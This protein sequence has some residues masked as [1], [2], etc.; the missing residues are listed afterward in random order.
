MKQIVAIPHSEVSALWLEDAALNESLELAPGSV[1]HV[2]L[3]DG[4]TIMSK[5]LR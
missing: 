2:A 5:P 3:V 1:I 4:Q